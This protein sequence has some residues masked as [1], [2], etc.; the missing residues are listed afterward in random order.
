MVKYT[1]KEMQAKLGISR[2]T[3]NELLRNN[4]IGCLHIG[5]RTYFTDEHYDEYLK[6]VNSAPGE[7]S[8]SP[9]TLA[10]RVHATL[11]RFNQSGL[12]PREKALI[13]ALAVALTQ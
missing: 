2:P 13:D 10:M 4:E 6:R 9:G 8:V 11:V 7:D 3:L 1:K 5:S 12:T